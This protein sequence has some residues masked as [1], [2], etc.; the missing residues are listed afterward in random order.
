MHGTP[1][2]DAGAI[3]GGPFEN[4]LT[5]TEV[6]GQK[7]VDGQESGEP[8]R[9]HARVGMGKLRVGR[10]GRRRARDDPW[11]NACGRTLAEGRFADDGDDALDLGQR[12]ERHLGRRRR[13]NDSPL[14][15]DVVQDLD[16][17]IAARSEAEVERHLGKRP[18]QRV[19]R[20]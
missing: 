20:R 7:V 4:R 15:R 17:A 8:W 14:R 1:S 3:A 19:D 13:G 12:P 11:Q 10:M 18:E 9:N 5:W 6:E 16:R 2:P